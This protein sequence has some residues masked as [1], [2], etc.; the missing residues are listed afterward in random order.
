MRVLSNE[1]TQLDRRSVAAERARRAH[2][3]LAECRF[4]AHDCGVNRFEGATGKC[5][6]GSATRLFSAQVEVADELELIPTFAVALGGC[7][8]RCDFCITGRSSWNAS[9]GSALLPR[10]LARQAIAALAAGAKSVMILGGEPTIHLPF[11]LDLV[12]HLP[13]DARLIFKTNAHGSSK[14]RELI[15]GLFDVYLADFKFGNDACAQHLA[16]IASYTHIVQENLLWAATETELIV[17]HLL[18]PGHFECCWKPVAEWLAAALPEVKV[19]LRSGYWPA[20]Q[21][22]RHPELRDTVPAS[23]YARAVQIARDLGLRLIS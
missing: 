12:A 6:A 22:Q 15:K 19:S 4:C 10:K 14:A 17:R 1:G 7:D 18:M 23:D 16:R 3:L 21:A 5:H 8:L 20:W 11:V 9:A 13:P 2:S